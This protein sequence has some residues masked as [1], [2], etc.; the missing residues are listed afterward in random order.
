MSSVH[1]VFHV[2]LL[3]P[4]VVCDDFPLPRCYHRPPPVSGDRYEVEKLLDHVY[5]ERTGRCQY[6]VRWLGYGEED[7]LWV[8]ANDI[9]SP[10]IAAYHAARDK[11]AVSNPRRWRRGRRRF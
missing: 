6:L 11:S 5:D 8:D 7:D 3:R 1:P 4:Y 10:I 9:D 2:S